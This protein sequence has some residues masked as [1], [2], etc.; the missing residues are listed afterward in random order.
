MVFRRLLGRIHAGFEWWEE[1][2]IAE[3]YLLYMAAGMYGG[4]IYGTY[5]RR[6]RLMIPESDYLL[7]SFYRVDEQQKKAFE[8][9]WSDQARLAQRQPGYEWT[10][11]YKALDWQESPFQYI[12]FRMWD[13]STNYLR[14]VQFD[15]TWKELSKRVGA[16]CTEQKDTVFR[17]LIDDSVKRIID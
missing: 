10:R 17:I 14:M 9:N 11:T 2:D 7:A 8:A 15:P 16:T 3:K 6:A 4:T 13:Q 5:Q 12:T 1:L